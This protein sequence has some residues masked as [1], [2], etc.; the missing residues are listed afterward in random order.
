LAWPLDRGTFLQRAG[1]DRGE[2]QLQGLWHAFGEANGFALIEAP[3]NTTTQRSAK[4]F[5][6]GAWTGVRITLMPS[7]TG[8]SSSAGNTQDLL[9]VD[10]HHYNKHRP[11]RA[12]RLLPP[13]GRPGASNPNA[14]D[15]PAGVRR[16]DLLG[17]LIH[18]Y[19]AA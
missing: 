19:D 15:R 18:A 1:P 16:R 12:I 5:A 3:D 14:A 10:R 11:H 2:L 4:P 9:R 8:S 6:F 7:S 17:G 13:D